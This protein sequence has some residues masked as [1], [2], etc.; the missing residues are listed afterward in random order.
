MFKIALCDDEPGE[1][2]RMEDLL[3]QYFGAR[4]EL[5]ARLS[6][7]SSGSELLKQAE[8]KGGFDL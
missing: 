7:F 1:L 8:D 6:A 3:R 2:A 4:P 5:A